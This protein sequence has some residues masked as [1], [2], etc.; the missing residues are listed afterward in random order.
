MFD[1]NIYAT[2]QWDG[3]HEK[4]SIIR[5]VFLV[6]F[7]AVNDGASLWDFITWMVDE[8]EWCIGVM[9]LTGE[10]RSSRRKT[11]LR[12][13]HSP[14][15]TVDPTLYALE[16]RNIHIRNYW[17]SLT[18]IGPCIVNIFAEYNQQAANFHNLF[19]SVRRCTCFRRVF[20]PS[21]GAQHCTYSVRHFFRPAVSPD[22][23]RF[24]YFCKTLHMFQTVFPSIIRSSKLHI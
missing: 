9:I 5:R 8:W 19:I 6:Y 4:R 24:L 14:T 23:S 11:C 7:V 17:K 15:P 3:F 13:S 1:G 16:C 18:F 22:V 20:R 10:L 2:A 21:S 12:P